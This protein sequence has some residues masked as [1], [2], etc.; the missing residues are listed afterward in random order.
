MGT[1]PRTG[2]PGRTGLRVGGIAGLIIAVIAIIIAV[3]VASGAV[4][5]MHPNPHGP[6]VG[7]PAQG[8]TGQ[9]VGHGNYRF[10]CSGGGSTVVHLGG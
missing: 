2:W 10:P 3:I 8:A 5:S 6:C 7:G 9:P 1:F 4:S